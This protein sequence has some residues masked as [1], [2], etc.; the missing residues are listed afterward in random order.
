MRS[1]KRKSG[2]LD[3]FR[4]RFKKKKKNEDLV[5]REGRL[6]NIHDIVFNIY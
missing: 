4:E 5:E 1:K 3:K 2:S 6:I